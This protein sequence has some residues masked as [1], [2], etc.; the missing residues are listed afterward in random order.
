M[1]LEKRQILNKIGA[2]LLTIISPFIFIGL[3][4]FSNSLSDYWLTNMQPLFIFTNAITSYYL[5]STPNWKYP[6]AFLLL[7][8]AFSVE[9]YRTVHNIFAIMFFI[10]CL[11]AILTDK[12][13]RIYALPYLASIF[14]VKGIDKILVAEIIAVYVLCA[15]HI[16]VILHYAYIDTLRH[17]K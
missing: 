15:Y 4:G 7:L 9:D 3:G 2:I 11:V 1:L 17:K 8:T 13:Y 10:L 14:W 5:F 6:S 12:R 16:T